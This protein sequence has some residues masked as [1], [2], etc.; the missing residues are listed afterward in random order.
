MFKA[1]DADKAV[2]PKNFGYQ[3]FEV[4]G[5]KFS[6][7]EELHRWRLFDR[8]GAGLMAEL[9]SHQLDSDSIFLSSLRDDVKK[10]HQFS[11]H[12]VG[13]RHMMT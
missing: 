12:A 3:D 2:D 7:M 11:V 8:T 9:G 1:W 13:G 10:E 6:A 5:R 4:K